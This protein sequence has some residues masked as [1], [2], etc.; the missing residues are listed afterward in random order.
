MSRSW[1]RC[2]Q[3]PT[4]T[5]PSTTSHPCLSSSHARVQVIFTGVFGMQAYRSYGV[6]EKQDRF[7][8]FVLMG[9]GSVLALGMMR[10][11][12]PKKPKQN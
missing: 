7:P 12:K 10:L 8:L 5:H 1:P 4:P 6:P 11:L 3:Q 2:T 9:T